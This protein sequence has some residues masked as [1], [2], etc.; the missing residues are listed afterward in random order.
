[1]VGHIGEIC[2]RE[3]RNFKAVFDLGLNAQTRFHILAQNKYECRK[4]AEMKVE[5]MPAL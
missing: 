1:M 3:R 4:T 2:L 5:M